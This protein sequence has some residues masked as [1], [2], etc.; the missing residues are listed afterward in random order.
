MGN[1]E[2]IAIS[3]GLAMDAFAVSVCK[4]LSIKKKLYKNAFVIALFFG[5]FQAFMPIL[6]YFFGW[7]FKDYIASVD[8]WIAFILLSLLGFKMIKESRNQCPVFDD[9]I[10]LR[11]LTILA[12]ATSVDALI[13]GVTFAFLNVNLWVAVLVIGII[14]FVISFS[15]VKI[16]NK[17]GSILNKKAEFAGGLILIAMG[18]K[19]LMEHIL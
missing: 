11:V 5:G 12:V 2:L 8:H 9:D 6:G 1:M 7:Q 16:G 4:G 14:T 19:I 10:C 15:G 13:V 18:T 17:F 3:V